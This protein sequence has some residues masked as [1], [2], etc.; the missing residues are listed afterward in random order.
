LAASIFPYRQALKD[1]SSPW[2]ALKGQPGG[3]SYKDW[4]GL[5]LEREDKFNKTQPAKVVRSASQRK[6]VGLWCFAW[7][8]D[9]AKARCWY[10]HRIPL[11]STSHAE[12][13]LVALNKVLVLASEA[14]LLLRNALKSARFA[15]PKEAKVDFSMIDIAFWQETE[16]TFRTLQGV[17]A[18]DSLRQDTSTHSAVKAWERELYTYLFNVFDREILTD[19]DSPDDILLRQLKARQELESGYRKH[20]AY[21]DVLALV[22]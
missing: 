15:N 14:L 1:P 18:V 20:K 11:I 21:K 6:N 19:A 2:L 7:D 4:L 3:I 9:N 10:Q 17:L 8:M 13:F 5:I 22:G 12:Q 16:P